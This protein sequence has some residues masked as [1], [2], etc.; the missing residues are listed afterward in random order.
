M[1]IGTFPIRKR[2]VLNRIQQRGLRTT[3]AVVA[4]GASCRSGSDPPVNLAQLLRVELMAL[5][6]ELTAVIYQQVWTRRGMTCMTCRT[7][8]LLCRL[9]RTARIPEA[10]DVCMAP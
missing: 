8:P 10:V 7:I 2:G 4:V 9:M 6:A 3:V 1:T 5:E